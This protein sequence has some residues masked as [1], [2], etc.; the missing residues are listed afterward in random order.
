MEYPIPAFYIISSK[1]HISSIEQ[2]DK[3]MW[4]DILEI[5]YIIRKGLKEKFNIENVTIIQEEKDIDSHFHIWVLPIW[6]EILKSDKP[7]V[8]KGN[9]LEHMQLFDFK[10]TSKKI[11]ECNNIMKNFIE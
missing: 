7:R 4:Y 6:E 8:V 3:N 5:I 1:K 2:M 10:V 11:L 9:V